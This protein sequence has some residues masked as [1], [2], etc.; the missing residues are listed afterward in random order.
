[1]IEQVGDGDGELEY[2]HENATLVAAPEVTLVGFVVKL[3]I[4][5]A[6]GALTPTV[7]EEV[8]V[9]AELT[10]V[11]VYVVGVEI[12]IERDEPEV[13]VPTPPS[14]EQVGVGLGLFA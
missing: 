9:P 6:T 8:V 5:G 4:T 1:M 7:T 2:V 12:V 11:S 3:A 14:I 10:H 13:S